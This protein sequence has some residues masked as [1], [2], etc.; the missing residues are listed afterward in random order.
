[1]EIH[2][3]RTLQKHPHVNCC[4]LITSMEDEDCYFV[5][6]ELLGDG[7]DLFDYIELNKNMAEEE[8]R[9]IF[10]QVAKA[11]KHLHTNRIVHRD[12]KDENVI[13]DQEGTVH[14]ID[15][16][17]ATYYKKGRKFDTFTGTLEYCAP[18]V[19]QGKPYEGPQQDIWACGVLLFTL[20]YRENPFYNIDD[21]LESEL[22]I[23]FVI[24]EDSIDLIKKM[25]S[26]SVEDRIDINQVLSHPWF[27]SMSEY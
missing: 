16:G 8:I 13:L 22:R 25:L 6:M 14:L 21:I 17:C 5:V 9:H 15:F 2:I 23:P 4:T 11:V 7:M 3:L 10:Y 1:M 12:I 27:S 26:R 20:I 19:L 18:E 24:S